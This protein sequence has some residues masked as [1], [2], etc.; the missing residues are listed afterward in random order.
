MRHIKKVVTA[1]KISTN[2]KDKKNW[3]LPEP[4]FVYYLAVGCAKG[5]KSLLQRQIYY[6]TE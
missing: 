3:Y 2:Y 1:L 4:A 6:K 5:I